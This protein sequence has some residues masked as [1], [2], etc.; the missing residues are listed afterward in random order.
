M[1]RQDWQRL[2]GNR[3]SEAALTSL[4]RT[5]AIDDGHTII[6]P[7]SGGIAVLAGGVNGTNGWSVT[8]TESLQ[9][10]AGRKSGGVWSYRTL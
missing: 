8:V 9:V 1:L 7:P 6:V 10:I 3:E 5:L 4:S 2:R